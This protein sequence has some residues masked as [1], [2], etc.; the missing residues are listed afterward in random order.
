MTHSKLSLD[1][2]PQYTSKLYCAKIS[3]LT[4]QNSIMT[5]IIHVTMSCLKN[6]LIKSSIRHSKVGLVNVLLHNNFVL[7]CELHTTNLFS[8][9]YIN[10]AIQC[11]EKI[12][13]ITNDSQ[14][15]NKWATKYP[16][17]V[18]M[19]GYITYSILWRDIPAQH[20]SKIYC[21]KISFFKKNITASWLLLYTW[22]CIVHKIIFKKVASENQN[23]VCSCK[24][25]TTH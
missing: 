20:T 19:T 25:H 11:N 22:L 9:L 2:T 18:I 5:F 7:S 6:N 8:T 4:T 23:L 13:I 21:I 15:S 12:H 1:M 10:I 16:I 17:F 3:L 24:P 14:F